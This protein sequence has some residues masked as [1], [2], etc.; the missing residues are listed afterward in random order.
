MEVEFIISSPDLR[1][2]PTADLPEF[3]FMGRSNCGKSSLI[4][5]FLDRTSVART[6]RKPGK[7]RLFNYFLIDKRFHIV[8]LPG[9]GY[10]KVSKVQ[11]ALW[12]KMFERY[13][14]SEDRAMAIFQ[15]LDVRHQPTAEDLEV[16]AWIKAS[17]HPSAVAITKIDKIGVNSRQRRYTEIVDALGM[18]PEVPVFP[19]SAAKK[20][21]R[22]EMLAWV[23]ALLVAN[24]DAE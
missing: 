6:S 21:G 14:S 3:A 19:T 15:L 8:D 10:A 11:R 1:Q 4:N 9:Y 13:L 23:E 24:A 22:Q 20:I 2:L 16:A 12:K 18:G 7:T 5:H 17:G